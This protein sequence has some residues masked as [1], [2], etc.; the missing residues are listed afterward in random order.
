[1]NRRWTCTVF[2]RPANVRRLL[3]GFFIV[4]VGL[5]VIDGFIHKHEHFDWA[6]R[7]D[8]FAAFGFV[9]CVAVIFGSKLLRIILGRPHDYY[10][11]NRTSSSSDEGSGQ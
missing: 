8:F 1:M 9:A 3:V 5:L 4:L 2:D 7:L 11:R 10:D 6:N